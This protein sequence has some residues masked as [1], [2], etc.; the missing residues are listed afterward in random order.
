MKLCWKETTRSAAV[1]RSSKDE[2]IWKCP[3]SADCH[4]SDLIRHMRLMFDDHNIL[5]RRRLL[6]FVC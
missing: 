4:Q 2:K 1:G 3:E 5:K 6:P